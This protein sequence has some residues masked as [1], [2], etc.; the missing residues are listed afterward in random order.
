MSDGND[1]HGTDSPPPRP[2][3]GR[4]ARDDDV[5]AQAGPWLSPA[6]SAR[7]LSIAE[8]LEPGTLR[9]EMGGVRIVPQRRQPARVAT[10]Q[11][12]GEGGEYFRIWIVNLLLTLVTLGVY[13]AWAKVRKTRYFWQNT[14]LDG[15]AF[16]YHGSPRAI[17]LGRMIALLLLAAYAIGFE[18]SRTAGLATIIVLLIAGPWLFMRAQRFKL[19]NTSWRGLR[20]GFDA[21]IAEAYRAGLPPLAIWFSGAIIGALASDRLAWLGAA[22]ILSTLLLPWIH[23]R[24]KAYQH[25]RARY[26]G[27]MFDF[28]TA[29]ASFYAVYFKAGLLA[30]VG[31]AAGGALWLAVAFA[32]GPGA[33]GESSKLLGMVAGTAVAMVGYLVAWPY[34]AAR[35]QA[36]VWTH[37]RLDDIRFGTAIAAG[38]LLKLT[39]RNVLLTLLTAG[40]YWPFAAVALARYRI[41]CMRA[42]SDAPLGLLAEVTVAG[43]GTAAGD[44]ATEMFGLDIGL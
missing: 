2:D 28:L 32:L 15:H 38:P 37:T 24:L 25:R 16:D 30:L 44:A 21:R 36:V 18:V 14:R 12:T 31:F 41:E 35:L 27:R 8:T 9:D 22:G 42:E 40:L 17:L 11:F 23:H 4:R 7:R 6:E 3:Y 1:S 33:S 5:D 34:F 20:F 19:V 39:V 43:P 29:T 13:S 10:L 26:G